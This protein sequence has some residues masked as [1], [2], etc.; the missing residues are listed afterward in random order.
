MHLID[1]SLDKILN[2]I[3]GKQTTYQQQLPPAEAYAGEIK[4]CNREPEQE[5][6]KV[7]DDS[8]DLLPETKFVYPDHVAG[9]SKTAAS[10]QQQSFGSF[11]PTRLPS[12]ESALSKPNE[13]T[14]GLQNYLKSLQQR[15]KD[16]I[17]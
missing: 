4:E 5:Q 15:Q 2:V 10:L 12:R 14:A 3:A 11:Q 7:C 6:D 9:V 17:K 1:R 16:Y 8:M 13:T